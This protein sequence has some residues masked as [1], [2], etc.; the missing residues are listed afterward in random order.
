MA[1]KPEA[2][3]SSEQKS[4]RLEPPNAAEI[5]LQSSI[6]Y[7][8]LLVI[9]VI[10]MALALERLVS[11]DF[12]ARLKN[13]AQNIPNVLPPDFADRAVTAEAVSLEEDLR[14]RAVLGAVAKSAGI[15]HLYTLLKHEDALY[16]TSQVSDKEGAQPRRRYFAP[17]DEA[18]AEFYDALDNMQPRSLTHKDAGNTYRVAVQPMVSPGGVRYLACADVEAGA[19]AARLD[20]YQLAT[21]IM[22]IVTSLAALPSVWSTFRADRAYRAYSRRMR[23]LVDSAQD[24]ILCLDNQGHI[25]YANPAALRVLGG[26]SLEELLGL[27]LH[28]SLHHSLPDGTPRSPEDCELCRARKNGES[29]QGDCYFWRKD[30]TGIYVEVSLTLIQDGDISFNWLIFFKDITES[31]NM[32]ALTQAVYQ[33]SADAH[34]IWQD[35]HVVECSPSAL[36]LFKVATVQELE[37]KRL[38]GQLFPVLQ[39]DGISSVAAFDEILTSFETSGFERREWLYIDNE[40]NPLPC[41]NTFIRIVYNGRNARFCCIRDLRH[42]KRTEGSLRKEREQLRAILDKGPIGI[43]I[44]YKDSQKLAFA[45]PRLC[46]LADI[47]VGGFLS[48]IFVHH[49]DWLVLRGDMDQHGGYLNDYPLQL[50]APSRVLRDYLFTCAPISYEGEEG[51]LCWLVDI[52]KMREAEQ[53]LV[54]ARDAAEEATRAKSDFL[55]RMSHEIRTP[56]NGIIGMTYLALLQDPSS[57]LRDY[58]HKIQISATGL[59]GII[60]DILDFS[61]IEAGKMDVECVPF[62]LHAQLDNIRDVLLE[63]VYSKGLSLVVH[64]DPGVP[65][66]VMGDPLRLRQ[67][68]LNLLSNAVKFTERGEIRLSVTPR[69][70]AAESNEILFAVK[71]S[72]I[73]MTPVQLSRIFESFAQADGSITRTYGGTGLGLA[74]TKALVELMGG[75]IWADSEFGEGSTFSFYLPL[76]AGE[77]IAPA[78]APESMPAYKDNAEQVCIL[79]AEDNAINQ[80]IALEL[81]NL[82]GFS[83]DTAVNGREAVEAA[84]NKD[85]DLILMDIQ[86]PEM[87][88]FEATRQIRASGKPGAETIPIIAMT[89]NAMESDKEKSRE[90]GMNDHVSKPID[91]SLLYSTMR[92]WLHAK[93]DTAD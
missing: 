89:A 12:D 32:R 18:P 14:H 26:Y 70:G 90:A 73:G 30:G 39:S 75:A 50:Y 79:L 47:N 65:P 59:L 68:V 85:Y 41:E 91:P 24:G 27:P 19:I 88:G 77:E 51:V 56:M 69:D 5:F 17:Y 7:L 37:G 35:E 36:N 76:P 15:T 8:C 34:V 52:T 11:D 61:K 43:G 45:N 21:L 20:E 87:D 53:A 78:P 1:S 92:R 93:A 23:R 71:D 29:L 28:A 74:I 72:G 33:S 67:I 66:V 10:G 25:V 9:I 31:R 81:L 48:Q 49:D 42:I 62:D 86:M 13:A 22:I 82:F 4:W 57:K 54:A 2:N 38:S 60:N 6:A 44:F 3:S 16:F 80:E 83:A 40:G 63:R 84:L 64:V 46:E 58:L 55:A